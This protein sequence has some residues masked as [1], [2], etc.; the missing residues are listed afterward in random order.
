MRAG[1]LNARQ[2]VG[3]HVVHIPISPVVVSAGRGSS[4]TSVKFH[5]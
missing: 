2:I 1:S 5:R 4:L 3:S